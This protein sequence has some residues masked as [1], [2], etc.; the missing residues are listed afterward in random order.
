MIDIQDVAMPAGR[1]GHDCP[2]AA[3]RT[4]LPAFSLED[5]RRL[6]VDLLACGWSFRP[7]AEMPEP[8]QGPTVYLRHDIDL[9]VPGIEAMAA[10]EADLDIRS[11]W[12]VLLTQHYNALYPENLAVLRGLAAD[13][14]ELGVHYDLTTYPVDDD[15]ARAHLRWEAGL[16]EHATGARVRSISMHQPYEGRDDVLK[17]NDEFVH[18]HDP[19]W[20]DGLMYVSDSCRAWRDESLLRC[21]GPDRPERLLLLCHPELWLDGAVEDRTRFLED[22]L[23]PRV[24]AQHRDFVDRVVRGVWERHP[25]PPLHDARVATRRAAGDSPR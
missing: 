13:G 16:L 2:A 18:P 1:P 8:V 23:L 14:H 20:G 11:S 10:V 19:A 7:V 6:L 21:F 17:R 22:S 15:A 25:G 9:H 5:Y 4:E 24:V 12:F 3:T